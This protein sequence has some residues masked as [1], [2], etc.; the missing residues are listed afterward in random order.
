[1]DCFWFTNFT[2]FP[3]EYIEPSELW[4][5]GAGRVFHKGAGVDIYDHH[6]GA[7]ELREAAGNSCCFVLYYYNPDSKTVGTLGQT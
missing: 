1:M 2:S 5:P 4:R 6:A 7:T 3:L